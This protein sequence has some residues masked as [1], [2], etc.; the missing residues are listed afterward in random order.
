MLLDGQ[1]KAGADHQ[2]D[3]G[4]G[5]LPRP[6]DSE[7]VEVAYQ[8]AVFV[9]DRD[10]L[11]QLV[12]GNRLAAEL[13]E[14]KPEFGQLVDIEI[15]ARVVAIVL[16]NVEITGIDM[17]EHQFPHAGQIADYVADRREQ[18][19]VDEIQTAGNPKFDGR[20]RYAADIAL[21]IGI[22]VDDL[23]LIAAAND[24]ERQHA[25]R[26]NNLARH[27][28]RHVANDLAARLRCFPF[29]SRAEG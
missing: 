22:A 5:R 11:A 8:F 21:V 27:V 28:D 14:S 13:T 24:T 25:G 7:G 29:A 2:V 12:I 17:G 1:H 19:A 18:H 15:S 20:A 23:E 3:L 10:R 9:V 4:G 16:R 6:L 26:V